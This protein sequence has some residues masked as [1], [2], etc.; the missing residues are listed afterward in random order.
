[1]KIKLIGKVLINIFLLLSLFNNPC[2]ANDRNSVNGS[3]IYQTFTPYENDYYQTAIYSRD[4]EN[5]IYSFYNSNKVYIPIRRTVKEEYRPLIKETVRKNL[6]PPI[7]KTEQIC[8][9]IDEEPEL[10][11]MADAY[12]DFESRTVVVA[13]PVVYCQQGSVLQAML[14]YME[15][16]PYAEGIYDMDDDYEYNILSNTIKNFLDS[17][18]YI[19]YPN[20]KSNSQTSTY[21]QSNNL[22]SK[23]F[24][25]NFIP[26]PYDES[27]YNT[28]SYTMVTSVD[29]QS[30]HKVSTFEYEGWIRIDFSKYNFTVD[31]YRK[32][33]GPVKYSYLYVKIDLQNNSMTCYAEKSIFKN[34]KELYNELNTPE[35]M[36]YDYTLVRF[37]VDFIKNNM[38]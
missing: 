6:R 14:P 10:Y 32:E 12:F 26:L 8:Q 38:M 30:F 36:M 20:N 25:G 5:E 2:L 31:D 15:G 9:K 29:K 24:T 21:S 33:F 7:F 3:G 1:M 16:I 18:K 27:A 11:I 19:Y 22:Y 4:I 37:M 23:Y 13:N 28:K 35:N 34:G 17:V